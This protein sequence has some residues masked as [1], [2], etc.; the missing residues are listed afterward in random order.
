MWAMN[1]KNQLVVKLEMNWLSLRKNNLKF[2][3]FKLLILIRGLYRV[4]LKLMKEN[5]KIT[6]CD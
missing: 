6:T 5:Q 2:K 3:T 4:Y 1:G